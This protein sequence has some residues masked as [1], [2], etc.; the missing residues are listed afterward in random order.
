VP[1]VNIP[2][3]S[4][5]TITLDG[6]TL[7]AIYLGRIQNWA[8]PAIQTLNPQLQLPN[9]PISVIFRSDSSGT[10]YIFSKFLANQNPDWKRLH[11]VGS[12]LLWPAGQGMNGS[13]ALV[14]QVKQVP[15]AIGYVEFGLAQRSGCQTV[16]LQIS[17]KRNLRPN[18]ENIERSAAEIKWDRPSLYAAPS[19]TV[20]DQSWPMVAITYALIKKVQLDDDDGR[21]TLLFFDWI[22]TKK[23]QFLVS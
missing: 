1:I 23:I 14:D 22:L 15:G 19:D 17:D 16:A 13:T 7:T 12:K 3:I 5:G 20:Q 21:D 9:L 10:S 6:A 18:L 8:D 2:G 11:G 4:D